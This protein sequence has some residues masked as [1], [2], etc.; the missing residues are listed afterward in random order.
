[1]TTQNYKHF[2]VTLFNLQLWDKDKQDKSTRTEDYLNKRFKLFELYCL[3]SLASQSCKDFIWLCLF[4][5][6][7]PIKYKERINTYTKICPQ[8]TACYLTKEDAKIL[9]SSESQLENPL[10]KYITP[11]LN[12]DIDYIIT[13]NIDNDDVFLCDAVQCI[14]KSFIEHQCSGIYSMNLGM[15]FFPRYNAILKMKY[16]H[17]HFLTLV[18]ST[19]YNFYTITHYSHTKA[20][21]LFQTIDI[22]E[23]P[24]WIEVVH[25]S[26]VNNDL[27]ITSRIKYRF[28]SKPFSLR[29]YGIAIDIT[30]IDL[31]KSHIQLVPYFVRIAIW[32]LKRKLKK[33]NKAHTN[34]N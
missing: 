8:F 24:F 18:E 3:P 27:R 9:F 10:V 5:N 19:K 29:N 20:R 25:D 11:Y 23:K 22:F 33:F 30:S 14:Q 2:V 15:Q 28:I 16:P 7:T 26:N 12:N 34:L 13:T 17:N 6:N 32:R 4:D 1:M 31:I 21:K